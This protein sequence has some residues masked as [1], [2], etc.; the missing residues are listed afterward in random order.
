MNPFY[1]S[2]VFATSTDALHRGPVH[3]IRLCF[4]LFQAVNIRRLQVL[5][6]TDKQRVTVYNRVWFARSLSIT[7][8]TFRLEFREAG[9]TCIIL[10]YFKTQNAIHHSSAYCCLCVPST[11]V[12]LCASDG[13]HPCRFDQEYHSAG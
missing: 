3:C 11:S 1:P 6:E 13:G 8:Q 5:T 4:R 12:S 2:S 9:L 7:H 10:T